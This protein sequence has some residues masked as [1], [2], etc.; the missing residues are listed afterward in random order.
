MPGLTH[1]L[2]TIPAKISAKNEE[3][4]AN[5]S[6]VVVKLCTGLHDFQHEL[7]ELGHAFLE[8]WASVSKTR[9]RRRPMRRR[10]LRMRRRP[11]NLPEPNAAMVLALPRESLALFVR[12]WVVQLAL[13][14]NRRCVLV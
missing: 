13:P 2:S 7:G 1:A 9:R 10:R 3:S 11:M 5:T 6:S 4:D 12:A 14:L 8:Y